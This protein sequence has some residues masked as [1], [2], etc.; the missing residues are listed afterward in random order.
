MIPNPDPNP[1]P[2]Y[3]MYERIIGNDLWSFTVVIEPDEDGG[4]VAHCPELRGCWSQGETLDETLHNVADAIAGWL[5]ARVE[6][7]LDASAE[8]MLMNEEPDWPS[9]F[10]VS[11]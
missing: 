11:P 7:A 2:I 5:A 4:Y 6:S 9:S 8:R 3:A 10:S 1:D